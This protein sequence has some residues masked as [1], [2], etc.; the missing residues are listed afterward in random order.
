MP[1]FSSSF[2]SICVAL[3]IAFSVGTFPIELRNCKPFSSSSSSFFSFSSSSCCC[4]CCCL[5]LIGYIRWNVASAHLSSALIDSR[6]SGNLKN[7][8]S[9][10]SSWSHSS[11][12]CVY[13][14]HPPEPVANKTINGCI[15]VIVGFRERMAVAGGWESRRTQSV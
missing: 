7:G 6:P 10:L 11:M 3:R 14:W 12:N 5:C 9:F 1:L 2:F 4:C 15:S 13:R 8:K